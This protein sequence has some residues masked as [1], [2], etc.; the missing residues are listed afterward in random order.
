MFKRPYV[1]A[2]VSFLTIPAVTVLAGILINS[3]DPEIAARTSNYERNYR[4]L[5]LAKTL[6]VLAVLLVIVGLW[7][8]TCFS[9]VKSK[10]RSY[11]WLP[12]ALF[13]PFGL[14]V[15]TML[16]DKA[17]APGDLYQQFVGKL[18]IYL[19]IA[20]ELILFVVVWVAAFLNP[21]PTIK[22]E[23]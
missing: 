4:L 15:L 7:F 16:S 12:W 14:I 10:K 23:L 18:K 5:S 13:G 2:I 21:K 20:Y 22:T 19:R 8:L 6:S 3:I 17:P 9:L 11:R 1:L